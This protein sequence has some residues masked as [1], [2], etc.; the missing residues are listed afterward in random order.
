MIA[1]APIGRARRA[2]APAHRPPSCSVKGSAK[3]T[4][5][6][7]R[8]DRSRGKL[9]LP[10]GVASAQGCEGRV[11]AT[12]RRGKKVIARKSAAVKG[13]CAYR[14]A[15]SVK[16]AKVGKASKLG[17]RVAFEGNAALAADK[18]RRTIK[19]S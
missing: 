9:A 5:T 16:R 8:I 14:I 2:P 7:V 3:R 15:G 6:K 18:A 19:V 4:G 12:V 10:A 1:V 11:A 17:V 13:S